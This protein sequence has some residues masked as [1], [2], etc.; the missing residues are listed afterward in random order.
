[1]YAGL[2]VSRV[3]EFAPSNMTRELLGRLRRLVSVKLL[4]KR[5]VTREGAARCAS[6]GV[7]GLVVSNHG[8]RSEETLRSNLE[9]VPEVVDAVGCKVP[10]LFDGGIRPGTDVFKALALEGATAVGIGRPQVWGLGKS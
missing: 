5:M 6:H 10:V 7:D 3:T 2:D 9:C 4:V 8:G 1:M